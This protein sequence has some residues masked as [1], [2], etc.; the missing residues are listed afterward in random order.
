MSAKEP[1]TTI[2]LP[3][4]R[5]RAMHDDFSRW[6]YVCHPFQPLALNRPKAFGSEMVYQLAW[7]IQNSR[8]ALFGRV[9]QRM[10]RPL[11]R[12]EGRGFF[13]EY[14]GAQ[15]RDST[16]AIVVLGMRQR[17]RLMEELSPQQLVDLPQQDSVDL[18]TSALIGE[19]TLG[20][21]FTAIACSAIATIQNSATWGE[22]VTKGSV[23]AVLAARV[24]TNRLSRDRSGKILATYEAN[25][26][27][28]Y[29]LA[30][31]T[32]LDGIA[33]GQYSLSDVLRVVL[34]DKKPERRDPATQTLFASKALLT[35]TEIKNN[36]C[37]LTAAS[38]VARDGHKIDDLLSYCGRIGQFIKG[39]YAEKN[40]KCW[41]T[42]FNMVGFILG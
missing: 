37:L 21:T 19:I 7:E 28:L 11:I 18:R 16:N 10:R 42:H 29:D 12:L 31:N 17:A 22:A 26:G 34:N 9:W 20:G 15:K 5:T 3:R 1:L 40:N 27:Q 6:D 13:G 39:G 30:R 35:P 14:A 24:V 38:K 41:T 33:K 4:D 23:F 8:S 2:F 32:L 25:R 36:T